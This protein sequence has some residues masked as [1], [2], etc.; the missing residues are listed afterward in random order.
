M[1]KGAQRIFSRVEENVD[2]KI[3][4]LKALGK[5]TAGARD[6]VSGSGQGVKDLKRKRGKE[7]RDRL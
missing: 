6:T 4:G 1:F 3:R 5:N 7:G 2:E